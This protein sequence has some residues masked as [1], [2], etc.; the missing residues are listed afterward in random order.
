L[1]DSETAQN[2][3]AFFGIACVYDRPDCCL[4]LGVFLEAAR[5]SREFDDP[6]KGDDAGKDLVIAHLDDVVADGLGDVGRLD[7]QRPEQAELDVELAVGR[8]LDLVGEHLP[9]TRGDVLRR[10]LRGVVDPVGGAGR[11]HRR[12]RKGGG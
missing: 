5:Q 4:G 9:C 2:H 1:R 11:F 10:A 7:R 6:G 3:H 12:N 8:F